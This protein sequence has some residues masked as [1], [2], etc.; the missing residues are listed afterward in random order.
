MDKES[1][2]IKHQMEHTR[3]ALTDKLELLEHQVSDT[4]SGAVNTV[5]KVRQSVSDTVSGAAESVSN[6]KHAIEDTVASVKETV[7]ETAETVG[8][9][10]DLRKQTEKHPWAMMA[11]ATAVGFGVGV[12]VTRV[13]VPAAASSAAASMASSANSLANRWS[14]HDG[15]YGAGPP[16]SAFDQRREQNGRRQPQESHA[17]PAWMP[18]VNQLKGLAIG[19]MFGVLRDMLAKSM[20]DTLSGQVGEVIDNFTTSFGGKPIV[21]KVWPDSM[22]ERSA[23]PAVGPQNAGPNRGAKEWQGDVA[24]PRQTAMADI[25]E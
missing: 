16:P 6:M 14:G 22:T 4:M 1:D 7:R 19:A 9:T 11:G 2:V 15:G 24:R 23:P 13:D 25:E 20:P 21:G 5:E 17:E 12:L 8:E 18:A 3:A 10:L